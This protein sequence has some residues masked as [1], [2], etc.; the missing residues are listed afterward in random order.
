MQPVQTKL[1]ALTRGTALLTILA[2]SCAA[3]ALAAPNA[4]VE[5]VQMP[6]WVE[7]N[8]ARIPLEPGMELRDRDDLKTGPNSRLLLRTADGS[9]VKLGENGW[10]RLDNMSQSNRLF[11]A[12]LNVAEGAFRFTTQAITR[13]RTIKRDINITV[14]TVTAGIRGTDV[15][16]KA[17]GDRDIVCLIEGKVE[18]QRGQDAAIV[19]DQPL[20][21]YIAPRV[22]MPLP[23]APVDPAQLRQWATETDIAAGRGAARIGGKWK[24][25]LASVDTQEGALKLY[26]DFRA[27]GYAVKIQPAEVDNKKLYNVRLTN[28]S[29]KA[30]AQALADS[31]KGKPGVSEPRVTM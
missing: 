5:A 11:A 30:E 13:N 18:V 28:L 3:P 25:V 2:A 27:A 14:A 23:I 19:M 7:R 26:D 17:A 31:L 8:G 16:G 21:F 6:A 12:A 10:L 9:F 20:S 24:V 1:A 15:W 22:G 4:V 29:S